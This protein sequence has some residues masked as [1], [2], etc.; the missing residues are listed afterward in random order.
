MK[1]CRKVCPLAVLSGLGGL[2]TPDVST[3]GGTA[4]GA[5]K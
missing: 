5:T 4:K 3:A 2:M 1:I